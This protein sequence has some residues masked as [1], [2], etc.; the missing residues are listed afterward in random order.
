VLRLCG[1]CMGRYFGVALC[2]DG[3]VEPV[4]ELFG[5]LVYLVVLVDRDGLG[6]GIE[7][8]PAVGTATGVDEHL[9]PDFGAEFVV[10]VVGKVA[11]QVS[12]VH[13]V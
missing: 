9:F 6:G 7:Y 8:D 12:A 1:L 11:E 2:H 4:A 3:S 10:E 13:A 5:Q